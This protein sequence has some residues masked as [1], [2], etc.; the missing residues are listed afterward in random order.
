MLV[1][2]MLVGLLGKCVC[3]LLYQGY[4]L[5]SFVFSKLDIEGFL[6]VGKYGGKSEVYIQ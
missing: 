3:F 6:G 2:G 5:R 4:S 1:Q